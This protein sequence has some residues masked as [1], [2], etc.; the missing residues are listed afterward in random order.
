MTDTEKL[1]EAIKALKK[2]ASRASQYY[3]ANSASSAG[4]KANLE[5][6][7]VIEMLANDALAVVQGLAE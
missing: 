5:N 6:L 1:A 7:G 3:S 2:I 4:L